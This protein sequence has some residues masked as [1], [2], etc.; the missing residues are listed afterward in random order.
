MK[1][2]EDRKND[3]IWFEKYRPQLIEDLIIPEHIKESFRKAVQSDNIPNFGL[4]SNNPGTGKSSSVNA[5]LKE[6]NGEA[7]FIN[8]SL[9]NGIDVLRGKIMSFA[10]QQSFDDKRKIVVMDEA[11]HITQ[12]GQAA[13]RGLIDEFSGN[14]TFIFTGN[15]KD[16]IIT[17]LLDR[18]EVYDFDTFS[19]QD[20]AKSILERLVFILKNEGK[21]FNPQDLIQVINT[22]YPSIRSM[23]GALQKYSV[24]GTLVIPEGELDNASK[25]E[26]IVV[27]VG[28]KQ[29][30]VT[31]EAI[32]AITAP[33]AFYG[34]LYKNRKKYFEKE[35]LTKAIMILAKYQDMD[36]RAIDK[37]LCLGACCTEMM[38][39]CS[40]I[41]V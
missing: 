33:T 15:Y 18:M 40:V 30:N 27:S 23:V 34:W 24:T 41:G 8:A 2:G 12:N 22:F 25:F 10:S 32:D 11:D 17:P 35:S 21:E 1:I 13:F 28:K 9:E 38:M 29:F 26:T 3:P 39:Q 16:K 37:H 7:L 20:L 14:C 5:I 4:F 36:T 19:K 6:V 31:L